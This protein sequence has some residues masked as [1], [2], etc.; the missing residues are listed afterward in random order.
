MIEYQREILLYYEKLDPGK[1]DPWL[2]DA[3]HQA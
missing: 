2:K 3:C 1:L